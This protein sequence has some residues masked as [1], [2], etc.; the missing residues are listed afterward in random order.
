MRRRRDNSIGFSRRTSLLPACVGFFCEV[1]PEKKL[2]NRMGKWWEIDEEELW[3]LNRRKTRCGRNKKGFLLEFFTWWLSGRHAGDGT[4]ADDSLLQAPTPASRQGPEGEE[5]QQGVGAQTSGPPE[6]YGGAGAPAGHRCPG[7]EG[8][9]RSGL[10][11]SS[12][13][14]HTIIYY[15]SSRNPMH[16]SVFWRRL[17]NTLFIR[18]WCKTRTTGYVVYTRSSGTIPLY[19]GLWVSVVDRDF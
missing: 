4:A 16:L 8:R 12:N 6:Q 13:K 1:Y 15:I 18:P 3:Y 11:M 19:R 17:I 2:L 14:V 7:P 9:G 5:S 10:L